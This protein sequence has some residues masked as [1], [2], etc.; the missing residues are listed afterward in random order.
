MLTEKEQHIIKALVEDELSTA[1]ESIITSD[2]ADPVVLE[3]VDTLS[4]IRRKF[5][6]T[7]TMHSIIK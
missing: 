4:D 1:K 2:V 6:K 7:F 5:T 3:Y